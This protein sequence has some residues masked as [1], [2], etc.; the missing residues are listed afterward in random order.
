MLSSRISIRVDARGF[1][2]LQYMIKV[3]D[4]QVCFVEFFVRRQIARVLFGLYTIQVTPPLIQ[5][6]TCAL[7]G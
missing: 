2:S 1:L 6:H 5:A 3:E 4:G 7:I